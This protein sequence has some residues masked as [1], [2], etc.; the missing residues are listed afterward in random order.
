[1]PPRLLALNGSREGLHLDIPEGR[2]SSP[3]VG[4]LGSRNGIRV[5]PARIDEAKLSHGD[6]LCAGRIESSP[7][8]RTRASSCSPRHQRHSI[9]RSISECEPC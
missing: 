7:A 5:G 4:D 8:G 2:S 3:T 1:M 9:Q 6:L